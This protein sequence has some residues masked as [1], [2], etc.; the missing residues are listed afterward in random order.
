MNLEITTQQGLS[1]LEYQVQIE[2][3]NRLQELNNAELTSEELENTK[4]Y[5]L[6]AFMSNLRFIAKTSIDNNLNCVTIND[7]EIED[8][9]ELDQK[10]MDSI[11]KH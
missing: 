4:H 6:V 9:L 11:I 1:N 10:Q 7:K 2:N 5:L 8:L 3:F